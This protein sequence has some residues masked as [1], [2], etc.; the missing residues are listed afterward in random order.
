MPQ[1]DLQK[2]NARRFLEALK[3]TLNA[4]I[5]PLDQLR[6]TVRNIAAASKTDNSKTHLRWPE[7]VFLNH[8]IIPK[9]FSVMQ[10][11]DGIGEAQARQAFL[12]EGYA[13][14]DL[15]RYCSGTPYRTEGHPFTKIIN[16]NA[17]E[18]VRK[19]KGGKGSQLT[20]ACPDFAFR[21]PFPFKIVFEGKYFE[22]GSADKAA[23]D[24][25]TN[26]Y[27]AFFYRSLPYVAPKKSGVAWDYDFACL[28][29]YDA[30]RDGTLLTAWNELAEP[31]KAGFWEGA[32][33]YVMI[34]R[35]V[36]C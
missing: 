18:I 36:T 4:E 35:S 16:S 21:N 1:V 24:L 27:Q 29:A 15:S 19:W 2:D 32:N 23:R 34:L 5:P 26:I 11:L 12:C 30:S 9:I 33:V 7:S 20:Q 22:Q 17:A 31:V 8:F 13:N 3:T 14:P 6:S 10:T 25:A 28:L